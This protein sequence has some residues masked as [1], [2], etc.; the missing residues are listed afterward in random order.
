MEPMEIFT[1]LSTPAGR[2]NPYPYYAALHEHGEAVTLEAGFIAVVGYD[3]INSVLRDPGFRVSDVANFDANFPGWRE[4]PVLVQAADWILNLNGPKHARIRSLIGRT[5][6]PR[7]IGGLEP[8]IAKMA[9]ELLDAMAERGADGGTVEF[10]HDFAYSLPVTV[11]CELIGI[12]ERDRDS[13]RPIARDLA[14]IFETSEPSAM[15]AINAA[16]VELLAYFTGLAARRRAEPRDDLIS[17]LLAITGAGDGRL[18][19]AELLNNLTLLLVGDSRQRRTCLA[20]DCRSCCTTQ[21]W[22]RQSDPARCRLPPSWTR[23]CGTT[24]RFSSRVASVTTQRSAESLSPR[25]TKC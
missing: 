23:R 22:A 13:F 21:P 11:I 4:M 9:E 25:L 10:M 15:P 7:R 8:A 12:P 19:D 17:D 5:F 1:A 3:A 18:T 6:T 2:A 14:L 16:A 24:R 20:T